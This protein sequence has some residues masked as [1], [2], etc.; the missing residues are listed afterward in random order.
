MGRPTHARALTA[1]DHGDVA[2]TAIVGRGVVRAG[3]VFLLLIGAA[4]VTP[5]LAISLIGPSPGRGAFP[6]VLFAA[7]T[8]HVAAGFSVYADRSAR[9]VFA[10]HRLRFLVLPPLLLGFAAVTYAL[11]PASLSAVVGAGV[12]AWNTHHF[13]KQNVGVSSLVF[14]IQG[15]ARLT[16]Q[17]RRAVTVAG[18]SAACAV[19]PL[20]ASLDHTPAAFMS[21]LLRPCSA[22]LLVVA[23]VLLSRSLGTTRRDVVSTVTLIG[24]VLFFVP[25]FLFDDPTRAVSGYAFAHGFQYLVILGFVGHANWREARSF[26]PIAAGIAIA[27][28]ALSWS[29]SHATPHG[30]FYGLSAGILAWHFMLDAGM[31]R[32]SQPEQRAW[33]SS[34]LPFL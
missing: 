8:F 24:S 5:L 21:P 11:L 18:A 3:G 14:R 4:T 10:A 9:P 19:I 2:A 7:S 12:V 32:L 17:E 29:A 16:E 31:W 6:A 30:W 15:A 26:A 25:L 33:A 23:V 20:A 22:A 1:A 34:R 27:V 28:A 13:A